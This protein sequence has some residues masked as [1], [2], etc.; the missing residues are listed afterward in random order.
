MSAYTTVYL[1]REK[2]IAYVHS[3]INELNDA[4]LE[5]IINIWLRES[6]YDGRIGDGENDSVLD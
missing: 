3:H 6:L 5:H 4:A 2:I 1:S